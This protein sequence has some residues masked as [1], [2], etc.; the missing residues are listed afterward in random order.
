MFL[1]IYFIFCLLNSHQNHEIVANVQHWN[2]LV[3]LCPKHPNLLTFT[4]IHQL[5]QNHCIHSQFQTKLLLNVA[6]TFA[7]CPIATAAVETFQ[8][9]CSFSNIFQFTIILIWP[10]FKHNFVF[11]KDPLFFDSFL[12]F[13]L[14]NSKTFFVKA[15]F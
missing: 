10:K 15:Q 5:V 7:C 11:S 1:I 2:H 3:R 13:I 12:S 6:K 14:L 8:V 9:K 4:V